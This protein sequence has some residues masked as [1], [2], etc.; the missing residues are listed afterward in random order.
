MKKFNFIY[1]NFGG[2]YFGT[3][4][5]CP[6]EFTIAKCSII[7]ENKK[8][9]RNLALDKM[10]NNGHMTRATALKYKVA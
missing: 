6:I 8:Q 2:Y 5:N 3:N 4:I 7:A 10:V 1:H 9:A